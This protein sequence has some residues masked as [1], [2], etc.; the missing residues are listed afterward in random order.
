MDLI[1]SLKELADSNAGGKAAGLKVLIDLG[2]QVPDGFVLIHPAHATLDEPL[3]RSHLH[4]LGD[5]PKAV[6]SSAMSEDGTSATFAGQ[7]ETFL[8][9]E[10][11]EEILGG[12]RKCIGAADSARIKS[13][14]EN[15]K[16]D[17]DTRISVIVQNMVPAKSAGVI[18]SVNP[19]NQRR[20]MIMINAVAG[21]GEALVSGQRDAHH[22][23]LYR[24]GSNIAAEAG[25]NGHLLNPAL[26]KELHSVTLKVEA[27][28][29]HPVDLEW[30]VDHDNHLHWLQVRPV[31][32]L[33]SVHYNELDT[34]KGAGTDVWTLGNIGEMMPGVVTPLTYSV[35]AEAIDYGMTMLADKVR[36]FRLRDRTTP[37]YIQMFY[38]R[39]FINMSSL[40]DYPKHVWMNKAGDVQ[41]ALCGKT[42]PELTASAEVNLPVRV[43]NFIR[44]VINTSRGGKHLRAMVSLEAG[45]TV[46]ESLPVAELHAALVKARHDLGVGFGH[47]LGTSAQSGTLYSAFL[48]IMTSDKRAPGP[49]DHHIA[50]MMLLNIPEIE[51][52][53]A[54]KSLEKF[55][56]L[57]I[58]N[59]QF[60]SQ[61]TGTSTEAALE[62]IISNSSPEITKQFHRFL[63]RHGHRCVR[64]SELREK[65][66]AD[67][68]V[69]LIH[70]LRT[71]VRAGEICHE[72]T[73]NNID[74]KQALSHL[75][76][77]KRLILQNLVPVAR[78]AVANREITKA[79][80]IKMVDKM[81]KG[82]NA[83]S[84]KLVE[85][86]LLADTD[87]VFFLTHEELGLLI[88]GREGNW[89]M[90]ADKRRAILSE[91]ENLEFDEVNFGI[92]EPLNRQ[93]EFVAADGQLKG[94]PVSRGVAE[95]PARIVNSLAEADKLR[96]GEIMVA[97]F[98]DIGW[99]PYFSIIAGLIT[100][101]GSPLSHGAVVAREY[102]IPAVVGAKG[103]KSFLKNGDRIRLDGDKGI[104]EII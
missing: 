58:G 4:R 12:I 16:K 77:V 84:R 83:L 93:E 68:P 82:Y 97:S 52:A 6:R 39:L 73:G 78:R 31:T 53:D 81:R 30:A 26:L 64:E 42:I 98:T 80:S 86:G 18:F 2:L 67:D 9:L 51:S 55:A 66:W 99:T 37:R 75:P 91:M 94:I 29:N 14:T 88:T 49:E 5:G 44:Q 96:Q 10:T 27:H 3:I 46:D 43:V 25:K 79:L 22:Y 40:M 95:G 35:S 8:G 74:T 102:G 62:M 76:P 89:T 72:H 13:Y 47:H 59:R 60:A 100:E 23:E 103:A 21:L 56:M 7:F 92:P 1:V 17:S 24:S 69:R 48:R 70:S 34:V 61:F 101:I 11:F 90:V 50:T 104:V 33:D 85:Q 71:R 65:T 63:E 19:V 15:I 41:F 28:Y 57:I 45:F 54:V 32:T 36:A 87:Q 38:N 20:D